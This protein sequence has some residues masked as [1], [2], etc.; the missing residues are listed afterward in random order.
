[1]K[2]KDKH[3]KT[4]FQPK[5]L[6]S[7][8]KPQNKIKKSEAKN[9]VRTKPKIKSDPKPIDLE[10]LDKQLETLNS[11]TDNVT[12]KMRKKI[13]QLEYLKKKYTQIQNTENSLK[14]DVVEKDS[15]DDGDNEIVVESNDNDDSAMEDN[16]ED[17]KTST[18]TESM[19]GI[20][21]FVVFVGNLPKL[22]TEEDVSVVLTF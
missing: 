21:R 22:V 8:N 13:R 1:M 16:E 15:S 2:K 5:E 4:A 11:N 9:F 6:K 12:K 20:Q 18:K 3:T 17:P 7:V 10:S 14:A 19:K